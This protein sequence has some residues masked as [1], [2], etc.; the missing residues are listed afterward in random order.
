MDDNLNDR[1][2]LEIE[3]HPSLPSFSSYSL[4]VI[5]FFYRGWVNGLCWR[6]TDSFPPPVIINVLSMDGGSMSDEVSSAD[7]I[8]TQQRRKSVYKRSRCI[9]CI[10][11]K[12]G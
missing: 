11:Q 3:V 1:S 6:K 10:S 4:S 2:K 8:S 9:S 5:S 7:K 12:V